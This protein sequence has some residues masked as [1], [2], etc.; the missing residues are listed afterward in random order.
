MA[1]LLAYEGSDLP[2]SVKRAAQNELKYQNA[3]KNKLPLALEG[4]GIPESVRKAAQNTLEGKGRYSVP[5]AAPKVAGK[6]PLAYEGSELPERVRKAAQEALKNHSAAPAANAGKT[7]LLGRAIGA[8]G[9]TAATGIGM[10]VQPGDLD[11]SELTPEQR[12]ALTDQGA[13]NADAMKA[14]NT[15]DRVNKKVVA[16][17]VG[18]QNQPISLMN[19]N[20]PTKPVTVPPEVQA[21]KAKELESKRQVIEKGAQEQLRTSQLSRTQ[22][23][24]EV[25]KTDLESR[26]V[27][28]TAEEKQKMVAAEVE[29]MRKMDNNSLAKYL[30]Y[31]LMGAGFLAGG[32]SERNGALWANNFRAGYDDA[33]AQAALRHK[34]AL[35]QAQLAREN[36]F[37]E[38]DLT[39]KERDTDS[40][41][42]YRD[43]QLD[44]GGKRLG[45]QEETLDWTKQYQG[46]RLGQFD[47]GLSNERE[48][49]QLYKER[50]AAQIEKDKAAAK[51]SETPKV[52]EMSQK[53]E[54]VK[55]SAFFKDK[56][57]KASEGATQQVA[58]E[59][60]KLRQ[61]P[62]LSGATEDE[63]VELAVE[64]IGLGT[65][66]PN[67]L[68][69]LFGA[70]P[71]LKAK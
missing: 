50:T 47:S 56:G 61:H 10:M 48:R 60:R 11:G 20:Q 49:L 52:P 4:S 39:R 54:A 65:E 35:E 41:I 32:T 57:V 53:D 30:S 37:K 29:T 43:G 6:L 13:M 63:L 26:G 12:A 27:E 9:G 69:D 7:G 67:W 46:A 14:A 58:A 68:M 51:K 3:I 36:E 45:L 33:R 40:N 34:T 38:R 42:L 5:K 55:I 17:T 64:N 25:V 21:A 19:P 8:L 24:E 16:E 59:V 2:E 62:A 1:G 28:A 44:I 15:V 22:A 31:A 18:R 23:A 70:D 71:K 66:Q